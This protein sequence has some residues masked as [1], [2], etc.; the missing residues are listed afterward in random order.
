[1]NHEMIHYIRKA[2]PAGYDAMRELVFKLAN[3]SGVDMEK[4]M[5]EY[6][7]EYGEVYGE[8]TRMADIMEEMVADGFQKIVENEADLKEFLTELHRKD[9]TL[10]DKIREFLEKMGETI[11]ALF[12]DNTY[13]DF[14]EDLGKD[15]ENIKQLRKVFAEVM[16][17]TGRMEEGEGRAEQTSEA[18]FSLTGKTEDGM[19]VYETSEDIKK[20]PYAERM[21]LFVSLMEKRV[22]RQNS[23]IQQKRKG[24]LCSIRK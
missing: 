12:E 14:A 17:D 15:L 11:K 5:A 24:V 8:D 19:E 21:K 2:N 7:E 18:K 16:A 3:K 6:E 22:P 13:A 4:R 10:F 9:K 20:M 1:M 23:K